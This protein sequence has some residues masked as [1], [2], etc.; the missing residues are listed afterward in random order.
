MGL[1]KTLSLSLPLKSTVKEMK[2][3]MFIINAEKER[4]KVMPMGIYLSFREKEREAKEN[5]C[6]NHN[7]ADTTNVFILFFLSDF[8]FFF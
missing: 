7:T 8:F 6:L 4:G 3:K 1:L 2:S 5:G